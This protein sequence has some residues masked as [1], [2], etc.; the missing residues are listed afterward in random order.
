M[1]RS[2]PADVIKRVRAIAR[3]PSVVAIYVFGS[4][5]RGTVHAES[6][7]DIAVILKK[8]SARAIARVESYRDT[9]FDVHVFSKLPLLIQFRV[10]K[11]G[12][13][14]FIADR[15]TVHKTQVQI[16]K[17][18]LDFAPFIQRYYRRVITHV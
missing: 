2:L 10:F 15:K 12:K 3:L 9:Y 1:I 13:A 5:A 8:E 18:Y 14:L 6:D 11:E 7:I 4:G 17:R 16:F